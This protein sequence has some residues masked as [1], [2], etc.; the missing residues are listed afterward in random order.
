MRDIYV[1]SEDCYLEARDLSQIELRCLAW[2]VWQE[3]GDRTMQTLFDNGIDIHDGVQQMLDIQDRRI[4]KNLNFAVTY[5]GDEQTLNQR[6]GISLDVARQHIAN[7]WAAFPGI[8][9]YI[10]HIH[11]QIETEG[12]VR[13]ILG[14]ERKLR[15]HDSGEEWEVAKAK[16]E[17]FN[18]VIQGSATEYLKRWQVRTA[19]HPQINTIHD[20]ILND[21]PVGTELSNV[22]HIDL[23][24]HE[25]PISIKR[26]SNWLEMDEI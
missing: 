14:R 11:N 16:R 21:V 13:T 24:E 10:D 12:Y 22:E 7:Y 17:G 8:K 19:H 1:A 6:I 25:T 20:E 15:G 3:T 5:G 23:A 4:A 2:L 18:T 9:R 26:G